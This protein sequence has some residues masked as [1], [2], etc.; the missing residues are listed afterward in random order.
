MLSGNPEPSVRYKSEEE[1]FI[2]IAAEVFELGEKFFEGHFLDICRR[3]ALGI[4]RKSREWL[5]TLTERVK[6]TR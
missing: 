4:T 3:V 5:K 6:M 2:Y 1:E